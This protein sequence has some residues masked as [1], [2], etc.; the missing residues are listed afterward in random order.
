[1][2]L[3]SPL[4]GALSSGQ[5]PLL[6]Q[7]EEKLQTFNQSQIVNG[8]SFYD[9]INGSWLQWYSFYRR[10]R[11]VHS[12]CWACGHV[13]QYT[14]LLLQLGKLPALNLSYMCQ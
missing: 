13:S 1:M 3:C 2:T 9:S 6:L 12:Y 11:H 4:V 8:V 5:K 10:G 14:S 7:G